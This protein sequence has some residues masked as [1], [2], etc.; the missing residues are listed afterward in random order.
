MMALSVAPLVLLSVAT[1]TG[2]Q[3]LESEDIPVLGRLAFLEHNGFNA[4]V[5]PLPFMFSL[6]IFLLI[7]KFAPHTRTRWSFVWPGALLAAVLFELGKSVFVFYLESFGAYE[8]IY[9]SLGSVIVLLAW[10]YFSGLILIIG[11]E[12]TSEYG[13]MRLGLNRGSA[14]SPARRG[15]SRKRRRRR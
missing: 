11:A 9:G 7:Y 1:T 5:R 6:T 14:G 10:V 2:L 12:F 4:L 13:R 15:R 8:K 3:V